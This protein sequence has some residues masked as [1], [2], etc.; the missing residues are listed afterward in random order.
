MAQP[1]WCEIHRAP[2]LEWL[3]V[4]SDLVVRGTITNV[5]TI[6]VHLSEQFPSIPMADMTLRVSEVLK[7]DDPGPA[8][9]FKRFDFLQQGNS[10]AQ[11]W[12]DTGDEFLFFLVKDKTK[13]YDSDLDDIDLSGQW[14]MRA[15]CPYGPIDLKNPKKFAIY[16]AAADM[17][18]P[19]D[20]QKILEIVRNQAAKPAS[21]KK[22][23]EAPWGSKAQK[24][25]F[26]GS[27][28]DVIV[29]EP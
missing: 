10:R 19:S 27:R 7:G 12:K 3:T 13:S 5:K 8:I 25:L 18:S 24:N 4:D 17:T 11:D 1:A 28:V 9:T 2:S 22:I 21:G 20:G 23:V 14:I 6:T 15:D 26:S 29:P 16:I